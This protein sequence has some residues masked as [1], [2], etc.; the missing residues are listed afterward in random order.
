M[1]ETAV[2][3]TAAAAEP[4]PA[5]EWVAEIAKLRGELTKLQGASTQRQ[6]AETTE[7][8]KKLKD[9]GEYE[10]LIR[11]RDERITALE[12]TSA[13]RDALYRDG[14]RDRAITEA[15]ASTGLTLTKGAPAHL[16]KLWKDDF[17]A[18]EQPDG[19]V[20]VQ[21][22][23]FKTPAQVA[24]ERLASEDYSNFVLAGSRGGGGASDGGRPAGTRPDPEK[25]LTLLE[26]IVARKA[27]DAGKV[28]SGSAPIGL[29]S[30]PA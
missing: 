18:I 9:K 5:P 21:T 11:Q 28:R 2:T 3:E 7:A 8:E 13:K 6:Q 25:P 26:K 29:R 23:D 22:K 17:E 20:R 16:L 24:K 19:T 27:E 12:G 10:T 4:V 30:K 14:A 15:L 1:A